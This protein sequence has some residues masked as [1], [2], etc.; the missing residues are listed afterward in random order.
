MVVCWDNRALELLVIE[1]GE[2]MI[3]CRFK[4]CQDG[5]VWILI[6]VFESTVKG[7]KENL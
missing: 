1:V 4:S 3:T 2:F 5:F 7:I 6:G